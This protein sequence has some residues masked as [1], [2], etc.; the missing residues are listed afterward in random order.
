MFVK[1]KT[2]VV[3]WRVN[4]EKFIMKYSLFV[5]SLSL[6]LFALNF[7]ERMSF[8][9]MWVGTNRMKL[10]TNSSYKKRIDNDGDD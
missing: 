4:E 7:L 2:R 1:K 5:L 6:S 10:E 8:E 9:Y 3:F